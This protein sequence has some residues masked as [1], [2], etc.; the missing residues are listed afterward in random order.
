M[1]DDLRAVPASTPVVVF[2]HIPLWAIYPDRGW[3]TK[4][5]E[6]AFS[7]TVLNGHIHQVTQKA[8]GNATLHTAMSTAFPE[9]AP[10]TAPSPGPLKVPA[11]TRRSVLGLAKVT[12]VGKSQSLAVVDLPL[13]TTQ[14]SAASL[15]RRD[16]LGG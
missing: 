16:L 11:E 15:P 2:A 3:G 4:G 5:S 9:L 1:Q 14:G 12:Y 6:Q 13:A 7:V 10:G 8:E